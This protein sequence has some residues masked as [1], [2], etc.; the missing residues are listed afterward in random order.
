M[1]DPVVESTPA[2]LPGQQVVVTP[3]AAPASGVP[4]EMFPRSYVDEIRQSDAKHRVAAREAKERAEAA[5]KEVERLKPLEG[6]IK[7]LKVDAAL[8][9]IISAAG[10]DAKLTRALLRDEIGALDPSAD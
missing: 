1:A 6:Q 10:V 4:Q 5:E 3:Q 8:S 2:A 7:G 9:E